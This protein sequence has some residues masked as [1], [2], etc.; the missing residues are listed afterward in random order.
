MKSK[1]SQAT[2]YIKNLL[3]SRGVEVNPGIVLIGEEP[4][5]VFEHNS[6]CIAID[7]S[8]GVW[9]GMIGEKWECIATPCSVSGALQAIEFLT[10]N[11]PAQMK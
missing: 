7:F 2:K 4:W 5:Q 3:T 1:Q 10:E 6:R 11:I 8:G 9:V